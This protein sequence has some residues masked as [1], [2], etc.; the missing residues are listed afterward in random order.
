MLHFPARGAGAPHAKR[1]GATGEGWGDFFSAQVGGSAALL[2]LLF[3]GLSI[4][5]AEILKSQSLAN[6]ALLALVL[7]RIVMIVSL[8]FLIPGLGPRALSVIVT[9][10]GLAMLAGGT[11]IEI[12]LAKGEVPSKATYPLNFFLSEVS[13][14]PYVVA[15]ALLYLGNFDALYW[16]AAGMILSIVKAVSDAW[17]LL[18][19]INR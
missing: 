1:T 19:E 9:A 18:V 16:L 4:N 17:V 10:I 5:L 11:L 3:V 6:R 8:V 12:S 13:C 14:V 15:G 7:L 2:G